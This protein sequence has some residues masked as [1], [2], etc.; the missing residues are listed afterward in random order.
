MK[1]KITIYL[2]ENSTEKLAELKAKQWKHLR[3]PGVLV[4]L[5]KSQKD[6]SI[7]P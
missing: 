2:D 5:M 1:I 7:M 6:N 3:I 4:L